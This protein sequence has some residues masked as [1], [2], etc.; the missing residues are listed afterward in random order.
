MSEWSFLTNH[1]RALLCIAHDPGV[2]LRDVASELGITERS[3]YGIVNDLAAA[4]YV[5]K[6]R[7][8]RRNRYDIQKHVSLQEPTARE[9]TIGD[10]LDLLVDKKRR[11][12]P[13]AVVSRTDGKAR[14]GTDGKTA[15]V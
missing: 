6:S 9:R 3:A 13:T 7:D 1:A 11:V 12:Q 5:V 10:M 15:R 14:A 8:G 2:R 4:G